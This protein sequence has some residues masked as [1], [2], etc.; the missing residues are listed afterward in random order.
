MQNQSKKTIFSSI[1]FISLGLLLVACGGSN[2]TATPIP[3]EPADNVLP[4]A[5]PQEEPTDAA[6]PTATAE[7]SETATTAPLPE[8][9]AT[10]PAEEYPAVTPTIP[11]TPEGYPAVAPTEA[12]PI[13]GYPAAEDVTQPIDTS[14]SVIAFGP[15]GSEQPVIEGTEITA[16]FTPTE[17]S[18]S[19]GCNQYFAE[20]MTD[21]TSFS[22]GVIGST[23]M[24]CE[25]PE[26]VFEQ[27]QAYLEALQH[28]D[29]FNWGEAGEDSIIYYTLEDG[30]AGRIDLTP[31]TE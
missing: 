2:A 26:G 25:E 7:P 14:F 6:E 3:T 11:P 16:V 31:I 19:A 30:T 29:G 10:V 22:I 1:L 20:R 17:V 21:G 24:F 23:E 27:E 12:P 9:T 8:P 5:P 18:G 13:D 15:I 28:A 4:T